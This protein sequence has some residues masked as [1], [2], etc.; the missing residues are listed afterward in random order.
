MQTLEEF[1]QHADGGDFHFGSNIHGF[2]DPHDPESKV[3]MI[4][5]SVEEFVYN[6]LEDIYRHYVKEEEVTYHYSM[7]LGEWY[8]DDTFHTDCPDFEEPMKR[9]LPVRA[10]DESEVWSDPVEVTC[11]YTNRITP[12]HF[13][14]EVLDDGK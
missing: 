12:A 11:N 2:Y 13:K 6:S 7:L 1:L 4:S 14:G 3:T 9:L 8:D 10:N 5:H